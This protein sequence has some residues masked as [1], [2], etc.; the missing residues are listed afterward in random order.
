MIKTWREK[1]FLSVFWIS[2]LIIGIAKI[3]QW[4]ILEYAFTPLP[5]LILIAL[6][7][8]LKGIDQTIYFAFFFCFVGDVMILGSDINYFISGLTA[9]WGASIL[10]SF[11]LYREL[12]TSMSEALKK[13]KMSLP[14]FIYGIYFIFLM[15]FIEPYMGD[16]FI[17]TFVYALSLSFACAFSFVVYFNN[18]TKE[19]LYFCLGLFSLSIAASI[20]GLNRFYFTL[21][22]LRFLETLF[23]APSLYFIFLYFKTK[24]T[25][26]F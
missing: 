9:Y 12:E 20:I 3:A 24:K 6:Y 13:S 7:Y 18:K 5:P 2:F 25:S 17:P 11:S 22:P 15:Y 14:F 8:H 21:I 19:S 26:D 23:Y 4:P 1:I 16:V 10:F